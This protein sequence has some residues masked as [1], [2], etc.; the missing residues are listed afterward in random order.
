M[1]RAMNRLNSCA[2]LMVVLM[3]VFF[4]QPVAAA[5]WSPPAPV[6][7]MGYARATEILIDVFKDPRFT[8]D[9]CTPYLEALQKTLGSISI[10]KLPGIEVREDEL[11]L[12]DHSWQIRQVLHSRLSEYDESCVRQIQSVFRSFR[13]VEDYVSEHL[14]C[15]ENV[16]VAAMKSKEEKAFFDAEPVPMRSERPYY[17]FVQ[18]DD[19]KTVAYFAAGDLLIARGI[20]FLS[21]MIARL[22]VY[23]TQF[24]HIVF[25]TRTPEGTPQTI[26]SYVGEGVKYHQQEW[27]LK[28][29]NSRLLWLRPKE[30]SI[31]QKASDY[32]RARL[33]KAIAENDPILYDYGLDFKDDTTMSCAEVAQVAYQHA[34]DSMKNFPYYPNKIQEAKSFID[35][36]GLTPG[37]TFEPGDMEI[38]P[39]FE[40]LGEFTDLRL[41]RESRQ[42]D[43]IMTKVFE[44]MIDQGYE[45]NDSFKSNLAGGLIKTMSKGPFYK[46]TKLLAGRD[47]RQI[48]RKMLRTSVLI[49]QIGSAMLKQLQALDDTQKALTG[50]PMD[51][52]EL[53]QALEAMR[54]ADLAKYL[55]PKENGK[56]KFHQWLRPNSTSASSSR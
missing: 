32:M 52:N 18:K 1:L 29:E 6:L 24:S 20:S 3:T 19:A 43:A 47:V 55:N 45:L 4:A 36:L 7:K 26:E 16:S 8:S 42:M 13:F 38:D 12:L 40:L 28:N 46:L 17:R 48:P 41:T 33:D 56:P 11:K 53:Y 10:R 15:V 51:Y 22:G 2:R 49:D 31:G 44:W 39:R 14:E 30:R 5:P 21:A 37:E 54:V 25:V 35:H 9:V 27:A 34:D 50:W 23:S